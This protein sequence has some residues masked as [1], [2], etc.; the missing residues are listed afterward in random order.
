MVARQR[1]SVAAVEEVLDGLLSGADQAMVNAF[2]SGFRVTQAKTA[3][4]RS[5]S[6]PT[7]VAAALE[8]AQIVALGILVREALQ[9]AQ[10]QAVY[11]PFATVLP[12]PTYRPAP[13]IDQQ[14]A[15]F[16]RVLPDLK[17]E[18][19]QEVSTVA[20]SLSVP[21]K[22]AAATPAAGAVPVLA[23]VALDPAANYTGAWKQ[24][25]SLANQ[26]GRTQAFRV[27][28]DTAEQ[29]APHDGLGIVGFAGVAAAAI[30]MRD[31]LPIEKVLLLYEPFG[32]AF[33]Y[34]SLG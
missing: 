16:I 6:D 30:F 18:I 34:E 24:V 9:P 27:M 8:S 4:E 2:T 23:P 3:I 21:P 20:K 10:F 13:P 15:A 14:I 11:R 32:A 31:V 7:A 25:I 1:P 19:E 5:L 12:G 28:Q 26:T 29:A 22:P 33:P 17:G